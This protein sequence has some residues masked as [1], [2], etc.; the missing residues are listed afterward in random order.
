MI[1]YST[2]VTC[3]LWSVYIYETLIEDGIAGHEAIQPATR[4]SRLDAYMANGARYDTWDPWIGLE[5]FLQLKEG[6]SW[7]A[8]KQLFARYRDFAP[9]DRPGEVDR[10]DFLFL[11]LSQVVGHNLLPFARCW[12]LPVSDWVDAQVGDLPRWADDPTLAYC[13]SCGDGV[14]F[15][16]EACDDGNLTAGD[17]CDGS[18]GVEDG[19]RCVGRTPSECSEDPDPVVEVHKPGE[20][21]PS[22]GCSGGFDGSALLWLALALRRRRSAPPAQGEDG[23]QQ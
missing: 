22:C 2:E 17:G 21:D 9:G 14:Q 12:G 19:F 16:T 18:C 10:I 23:Q 1:P 7:D 4:A 3:N 5:M 20:P 11:N 8:F 13:G 6:F 15:G